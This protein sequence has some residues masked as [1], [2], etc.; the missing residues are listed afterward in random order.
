MVINIIN[1]NSQSIHQKLVEFFNYVCKYN[2]SVATISE[3]WLKPSISFKHSNYI[4]YRND[5][6]SAPHGGVA[7]IVKNDIKHELLPSLHS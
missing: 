7:I 6:T 2:I 4:C 5:R 3:T 1:W